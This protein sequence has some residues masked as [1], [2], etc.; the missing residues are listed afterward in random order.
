MFIQPI[1]SL[2]LNPFNQQLNELSWILILL[3]N[4]TSVVF[5]CFH[6]GAEA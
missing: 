2:E 6:M 1:E 3:H 5:E 4:V